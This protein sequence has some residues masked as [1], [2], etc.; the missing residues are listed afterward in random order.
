M[1]GLLYL[2]LTLSLNLAYALSPSFSS[3]TPYGW[4]WSSKSDLD[5]PLDV[6][7][8]ALVGPSLSGFG[9]ESPAVQ[10]MANLNSFENSTHADLCKMNH[11]LLSKYPV[12]R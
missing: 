7:L 10:S 5:P 4:E 2:A 6:L 11:E 8:D 12:F 9:F 3:I 1:E